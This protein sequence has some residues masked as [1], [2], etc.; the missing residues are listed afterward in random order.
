MT[1]R[2]ELEIEVR[3]DRDEGIKRAGWLLD[4]WAEH[5]Y[6]QLPHRLLWSRATPTRNTDGEVNGWSVTGRYR[7]HDPATEA[8]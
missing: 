5:Y 4:S 7:Q 6:G 8:S 2:H 3:V 1:P